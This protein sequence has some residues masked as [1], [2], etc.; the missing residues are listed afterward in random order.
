MAFKKL[1]EICGVLYEA[2]FSGFFYYHYFAYILA[3]FSIKSYFTLSS[4]MCLCKIYMLFQVFFFFF[5]KFQILTSL[6]HNK[7]MLFTPLYSF[8]PP[9]FS[10]SVA[11]PS[12]ISFSKQ[13]PCSAANQLS[14]NPLCPFHLTIKIYFLFDVKCSIFCAFVLNLVP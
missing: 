6:M 4:M 1:S 10:V 8:T 5:L 11:F 14:S 9:L 7:N 13:A 2:A 12:N 3:W